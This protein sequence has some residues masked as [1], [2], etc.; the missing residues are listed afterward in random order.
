MTHS[1]KILAA[2]PGYAERIAVETPAQILTYGAL[3]EAVAAVQ[4]LL[5]GTKMAAIMME[6]SPAWIVMDIACIA[7]DVP[8]LPLPSFFSKRQ[9]TH[10]LADA[11]VDTIFTDQPQRFAGKSEKIWIAEQSYWRVTL[12]HALKSLPAHTAK[13][14]YTSGTTDEPKGVCLTQEAM[15]TVAWSLLSVIDTPAAGRHICLLPLAVLLENIAGVYTAL[16]A[17]ATICLPPVIHEPEVLHAAINDYQATSCIL[18]PE[19]LRMLLAVGKPLPS[20]A[21]VAVGGARVAPELLQAALFKSIPVYEGY[22][23]TEAA[24]VVAVNTPD[25]YKIGSAG[26]LL[27]HIKM[28]V[29]GN[30]ELHLRHPLFSG[31]LG[32][33][34]PQ[35]EWYPTGD[36]GRID[37]DG[38]LFIEGRKK[39]VYITSFG[40][41]VSPEWIE[42]VLTASPAIAQAV[43]YGEAKPFSTAIIVPRQPQDIPAVIR[44]INNQLPDYAR[45]GAHVLA[46]EPF[47]IS[48]GQLTG[49]GRPRRQ[50]VYHIYA[51]AIDA[52]YARES[53]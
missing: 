36:I 9:I 20:L 21:Y 28:H 32:D 4:N 26:K 30:G 16:L 46:R 43:I 17:G 27:P 52:C 48:N 13:I 49:T 3:S 53:V 14:T 41:N 34:A 39:N 37:D 42:S 1:S 38:F 19:L 18:V 33:D 7:S 47:S 5:H 29:D 25:A 31:Y 35:H 40:R 2:L 22:G 11:G 51:D 50:M 6:N 23:L 44:Q 15:E 10:A 24:S 8:L 12:A 45:I